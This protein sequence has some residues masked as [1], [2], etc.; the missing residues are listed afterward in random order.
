MC[1]SVWPPFFHAGSTLHLVGTVV[2][3]EYQPIS[4]QKRVYKARPHGGGSCS[5]DRVKEDFKGH[6]AVVT[7]K[8]RIKISQK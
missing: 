4:F 5:Q 2:M 7:L 1:I 6:N 8:K 3:D